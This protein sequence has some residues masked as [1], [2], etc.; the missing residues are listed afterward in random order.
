MER[1]NALESA[2][3]ISRGFPDPGVQGELARIDLLRQYGRQRIVAG[4]TPEDFETRRR[5]LLA[6]LDA[7]DA[8]GGD[9]LRVRTGWLRQRAI[10]L[11]PGS[12][13]DTELRRTR[14]QYRRQLDRLR[15]EQE[16]LQSADDQESAPYQDASLDR[17][18]IDA[19]LQRL[20]ADLA[21]LEAPPRMPVAADADERD[22]RAAALDAL[23]SPCLKCHDYD[24]SGAR[25]APVRIAEPVMARSVFNHA[26][27]TTQTSCET[28]HPST[29]TS[30]RA[31][32]VNVL[33]VALCMTCHTPSKAGADCEQCHNYHPPSVARLVRLTP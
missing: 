4:L 31:A 24:P 13:G 6:L 27:H 8:R 1:L 2:F 18:E 30:K 25:L 22:T 33:G 28:C 11:R 17:T 14:Q 21:S 29:K 16:L 32:D 3:R 15:L 19:L 26:P 20:R 5:E 12:S 9:A 23:L 7:I 10:S